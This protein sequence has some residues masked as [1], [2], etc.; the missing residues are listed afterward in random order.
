MVISLI[1]PVHNGARVISGCLDSIGKSRGIADHELEIIVIDDGSTDNTAEVV[2]RYPVRYLPI[3]KAGVAAARNAGIAT[4][5]GGVLIFFDADVRLKEDTLERMLIH[6]KED[7]DAMVIQGR[8]DFVSPVPG[9]S[10][11]FQLLKYHYCFRDFFQDRN[12]IKVANLE[13]GCLA[14]RREIFENVGLFHTGY[15]HA[16]GEEHELGLRIIE[17]YDIFYYDD[18]FV[19]HAFGSFRNLLK[20]VWFRTVNFTILMLGPSGRKALEIHPSAPLRERLNLLFL[21]LVLLVGPARFLAP[22]AVVPAAIALV[23]AVIFTNFR[24]FFYLQKAR[25]VVFALK[26]VA[27]D[28]ILS[29]PK[30]GGVVT[31]LFL[32]YV[33]GKKDFRI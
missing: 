3:L 24:F 8:W 28:L 12:R 14:V 15:R 25:G 2:R 1:I 31:A 10:S 29:V 4:A 18:V 5:Q 16:G 17:K 30:L 21:G 26:G 9:F 22:S 23:V 6:L 19:E 13:S 32:Y 33:S 20:K 11:D 27:C 7:S